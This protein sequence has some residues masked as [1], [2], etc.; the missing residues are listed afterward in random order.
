MEFP[1]DEVV[2]HKD[3]NRLILEPVAKRSCLLE[4]LARWAPIGDEFP[5]VDEGLSALDE[6]EL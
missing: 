3:G 2:I 1:G 5:D 6:V 4:L